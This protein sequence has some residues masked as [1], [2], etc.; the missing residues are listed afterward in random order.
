MDINPRF[1]LP[2]TAIAIML[3]LMCLLC[4][5]ML[6]KRIRAREVVRG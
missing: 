4:L 2:T 6:N 3:S 1:V 5:G